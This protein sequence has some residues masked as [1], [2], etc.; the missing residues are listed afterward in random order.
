MIKPFKIPF[1]SIFGFFPS[2]Q[3]TFSPLCFLALPR[4]PSGITARNKCPSA[5]GERNEG[6]DGK[7]VMNSDALRRLSPLDGQTNNNIRRLWLYC[8]PSTPHSPPPRIPNSSILEERERGNEKTFSIHSSLLRLLPFFL[9]LRLHSILLSS[10]FSI[11]VAA[12]PSL[13][14]EEEL[15]PLHGGWRRRRAWKVK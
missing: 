1:Y 8:R 15:P 14:R 11:P 5:S 9:P 7:Y 10:L 2:F 13:G 12:S 3:P 4:S 6:R